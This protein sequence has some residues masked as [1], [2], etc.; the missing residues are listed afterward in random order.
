MHA[1]N[2]SISFFSLKFC[3]LMYLFCVLRKML[4]QNI[5]FLPLIILCTETTQTRIKRKLND[6]LRTA[7][8][9]YAL[10]AG[11]EPARGD[12]NGFLVHRL[13]H[14]ATTTDAQ[15]MCKKKENRPGMTI[16]QVWHFVFVD[17]MNSFYS[18]PLILFNFHFKTLRFCSLNDG[19]GWGVIYPPPP[20]TFYLF[21]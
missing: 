12:P 21:F 15:T 4:M 5:S 11:F 10:S 8:K 1:C 3:Y 20:S 6:G 9:K 7:G 17:T 16:C 14:S 2:K 13:N 18:K 19:V